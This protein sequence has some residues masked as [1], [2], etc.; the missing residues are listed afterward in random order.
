MV[1][2][3]RIKYRGELISAEEAR[4]RIMELST[5]LAAEAPVTSESPV[6][7][8]L[9]AVADPRWYTEPSNQL[10]GTLLCFRDNGLGWRGYLLPWQGVAQLIGLLSAQLAMAAEKPADKQQIH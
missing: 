4:E 9:A 1:L 6:G 10:P 7:E 2:K 5:L 8:Q 3:K